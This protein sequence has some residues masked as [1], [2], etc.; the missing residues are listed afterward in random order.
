MEVIIMFKKEEN[1]ETVLRLREMLVRA[2]M[3][4]NQVMQELVLSKL[5]ELDLKRK[6]ELKY[7]EKIIDSNSGDNAF[8]K[9]AQTAENGVKKAAGLASTGTRNVAKVTGVAASKADRV[10][11]K[12]IEKSVIAAN[13]TRLKS[14]NVFSGLKDAFME[15]WNNA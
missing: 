12:A 7:A 15:G 10:A 5:E 13:S 14:E 2:L 3:A 4:D 6:D 8:K 9:L 11:L 1:V